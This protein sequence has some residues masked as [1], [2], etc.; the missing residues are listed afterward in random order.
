MWS[1]ALESLGSSY[2]LCPWLG[3]WWKVGRK[4]GSKLRPLWVERAPSPHSLAQHTHLLIS[5]SKQGVVVAWV[6]HKPGRIQVVRL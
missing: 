2:K 4:N 5:D 6:S 3:Q 1:R